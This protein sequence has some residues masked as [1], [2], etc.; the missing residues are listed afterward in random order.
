MRFTYRLTTVILGLVAFAAGVAAQESAYR[1][2]DGVTYPRIVK[3]VKPVYT[4]AARKKRIQGTVTM[5]VVVRSDGTVGDVNVTKSLDTEFGLDDEAVR[6]VK[7]WV[8]DPG[9]MDGKAVA[10]LVQIDMSISLK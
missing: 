8:F 5:D 2:G 3:E 10:V 4:D 6:A 1:P 7:Q 9:T